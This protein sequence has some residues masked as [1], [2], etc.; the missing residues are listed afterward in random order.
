MWEGSLCNKTEKQQVGY[1]KV[2]FISG[3]V[4]QPYDSSPEEAEK[5]VEGEGA[6]YYKVVDPGPVARVQSKLEGHG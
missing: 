6:P 3:D 2:Q 4:S 5:H 1:D